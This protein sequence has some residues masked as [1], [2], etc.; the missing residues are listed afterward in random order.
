MGKTQLGIILIIVSSILLLMGLFRKK[1]NFIDLRNVFAGHFKMFK[2]SRIQFIVFYVCTLGSAIGISLVY[3]ADSTL[4]ENIIVV[5]SIFVSMLMA[6]LSLMKSRDY[7]QLKGKQKENIMEVIKETDNQV[8]YC[9]FISIVVIICSLIMIAFSRFD[10]L[11][12]M[13]ITSAIIY[14]LIEV[15]LL[16]ILLVMKRLGKLL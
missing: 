8:V 12:F 10:N 11:I 2:N 4:Y 14:Y 16:N 9:T 6:M 13:T 5:M 1:N 3:V 7:S 15:V